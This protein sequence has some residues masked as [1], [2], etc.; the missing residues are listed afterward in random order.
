VNARPTPNTTTSKRISPR[1]VRSVRLFV[2]GFAV[3][4]LA[5]LLLFLLLRDRPDALRDI[6]ARGAWRVGMDPSF[7]PF[8]FVDGNGQ[9]AGL[10]VDLARALGE[11]LGIRTELV[12]LGFDE[13]IDA[14]A[15]HRI[16]AAISALPI[17]PERT[18]DVRFSDPYAQAGVVLAAREG[19]GLRGP[20]DL[21]GLSVAVEW[22]SQGDAEA[23][24][25][26]A[27]AE[28][29]TLFALKPYDTVTAALDALAAGEVDAAVVD[30]ISLA[31]H[32]RAAELTA[33]GEPLVSDPYVVVVAADAPDLLD[34][35]NEALRRLEGD[36]RLEALRTR[37][38]R[39]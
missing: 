6:Q 34:A 28:A 32:P 18:Q 17:M 24:R 9:A 11:E 29:G 13:L 12:T 35:V 31:M 10:D 21:G 19:S 37:W 15:A 38:L 1:G 33:V 3:G 39:P 27:D 16:D 23:R 2:L 26:N 8:E 25:L 4:I 22:G 14:V 7:P 20:A 36:G 5:L 30:A